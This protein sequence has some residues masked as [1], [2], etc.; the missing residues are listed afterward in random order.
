MLQHNIGGIVVSAINDRIAPIV[1]Y[2]LVFV[3]LKHN[4]RIIHFGRWTLFQIAPCVLES[5]L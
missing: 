4:L 3:M 2:S 1:L 5:H